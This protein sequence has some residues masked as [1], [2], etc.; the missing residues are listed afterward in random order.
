MGPSKKAGEDE[1]LSVSLDITLLTNALT[2]ATGAVHKCGTVRSTSPPPLTKPMARQ[3][4]GM[5]EKMTQ[6]DPR[7]RHSGMQEII[8]ELE[9]L[10][11]QYK[12]I[13]GRTL[14]QQMES[15]KSLRMLLHHDDDWKD[16]WEA[17][18]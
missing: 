10:D 5:L 7:R 14:S 16:D 15:M 12:G 17:E 4:A 11:R 18:D 6:V 3:L 1:F 2:R 13:G 9:H 8:E